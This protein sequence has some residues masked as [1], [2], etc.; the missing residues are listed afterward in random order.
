MLSNPRFGGGE[1][2]GG[3][4]C[5]V[6]SPK[7]QALSGTGACRTIAPIFQ[8]HQGFYWHKARSTFQAA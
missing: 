8:S 5:S 2:G 1:I 7:I 3:G 6:R 4:P